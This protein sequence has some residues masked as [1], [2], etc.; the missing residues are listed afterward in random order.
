MQKTRLQGGGDSGSLDFLSGEIERVV[1]LFCIFWE[2]WGVVGSR[3]S[4][5]I[6]WGEMYVCVE[7]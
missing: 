4:C 5:V 3:G 6:F 7:G 1:A 2:D